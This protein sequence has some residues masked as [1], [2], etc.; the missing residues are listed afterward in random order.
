MC[1]CRFFESLQSNFTNPDNFEKYLKYWSNNHVCLRTFSLPLER[2]RR[3]LY[4]IVEYCPLLDSSDMGMKDW[5]RISNDIQLFYEYFDGFVILHGTDT[6]SYTAA[7]LTFM[8]EN[9]NKPVIITGAQLPIFEFRSDGWNNFLGALL[10]AG[11][12]Y[13]IFEVTVFF[14]NK[15]GF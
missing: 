9:L 8:F 12:D 2:G 14:N 11:G 4:T 5:C 6:L 15:V 3:I 13:S 10:I 1:Y 7:A